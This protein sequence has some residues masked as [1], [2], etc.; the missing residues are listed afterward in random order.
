MFFSFLQQQSSWHVAAGAVQSRSAGDLPGA[1]QQRCTGLTRD[2][3]SCSHTWNQEMS[4][5]LFA[6]RVATVALGVLG[7]A[8]RDAGGHGNLRHGLL[9]REQ[10]AARTGHSHG[11]RRASKAS[12]EDGAG[13]GVHAVLGWLARRTWRSALLASKVLSYIVYQAAPKDPLVLGGVVADHALAGA[14]RGVDSGTK[15]AGGQSDDPDARG[16]RRRRTEI[17]QW[18]ELLCPGGSSD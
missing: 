9:Y 16:V 3:R 6:A 14:G 4:S 5:A 7:T 11:P 1:D 12:A 18:T 10:A 15:S 8:G 13:T 2:C 17:K